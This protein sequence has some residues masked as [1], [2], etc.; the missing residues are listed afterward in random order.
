MIKTYLIMFK[1]IRVYYDVNEK[2]KKI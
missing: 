2:K 1:I